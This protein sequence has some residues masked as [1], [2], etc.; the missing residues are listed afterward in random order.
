MAHKTS[1]IGFGELQKKIEAHGASAN[2]AGAI[3]AKVG[4]A[5]YGKKAFQAHAASGTS[6]RNVK[7]LK[8][9]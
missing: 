4:R 3:A 6:M 9:K 8:G 5:K 1:Y 2:V 7:P